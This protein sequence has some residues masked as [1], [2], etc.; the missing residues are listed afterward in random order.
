MKSLESGVVMAQSGSDF[1]TSQWGTIV[2]C[3]LAA[4]IYLVIIAEVAIVQTY[5]QL[6]EEDYKWQWPSLVHGAGPACMLFAL[7]L[8]LRVLFGRSQESSVFAQLLSMVLVCGTVALVGASVAFVASFKFN[9]YLFGK[10]QK[11]LD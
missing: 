10:I 4:F 1:D 2:F 5:L 8:I 3:S 7:A 6:C 11:N 9:Q